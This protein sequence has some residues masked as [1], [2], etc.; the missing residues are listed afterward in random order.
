MNCTFQIT[1]TTFKHRVGAPI[2]QSA[3]IDRFSVL[4]NEEFGVQLIIRAEDVFLAVQ[5]QRKDISWQG[6]S[7]Q[8]R[9]CI[10]AVLPNGD[11]TAETPGREIFFI[12]LMDFVRDDNGDWISDILT[13][14]RS[15]H[16]IHKEQGIFVGGKI[17]PNFPHD[18]V[19]LHIQIFYTKSYES[20]SL[21][22]EIFLP[23]EISKYTL[24]NIETTDF[25]T[26]LW[27]HPC[28]WARAYDVAYYEEEHFQIIDHYLA[29]L[30]ALGQKVCDLIISDFPWA[31]QRCYKVF[32]NHNNLFEINIIKIFKEIDGR[33]TCDFSAMDRYISLCSKHGIN[34]EINLFGILG[35]WD[36][37]DFGN[38]LHDFKDPIRLSYLDRATQTYRYMTSEA[39]IE[40]YLTLVFDHLDEKGLWDKTLILSD[41]PSNVDL[42]ERSVR[43]FKRAAKGK[44]IHL[45][46]AIHDWQFFENY[47]KHIKSLSLNTCELVHNAKSIHTLKQTIEDKGGTLTWYSC[48]FPTPMNIFLKSPLI[49]SR[50]IGWFT[51]Y[52][53]LDGFLRWAYG[54][55]P[56]DV[57]QNASYKKEKW[58]AGDMFLVYPGKQGKPLC[59]LRLKNILHGIQDYMFLKAVQDKIGRDALLQK[60]A[61]LLGSKDRMQFIPEREVFLEHDL[62]IFSYQKLKKELLQ[63]LSSKQEYLKKISDSVVEMDEDSILIAIDHALANNVSSDEI[64]EQGLSDG[65]LRVTKLFE[66]REYFVSEVIVCADTL[67]KGI[68]YLKS[69]FPLSSKDGPKVVMG[70]VEGDLHEIGK[71]IVKILFEAAGFDVIDMGLNVKAQDIVHKA[72]EERADIIG[73]S[74]MMT[75]TMVKMKEVIDLLSDIQAPNRP[76][77]IIGG[78]CI[79]EKY[80][81]EIGAD[82][83]SANAVEAVKLVQRLTGGNDDEL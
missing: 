24:A 76:K 11:Q 65:M 57:Y 15:I 66:D 6:L 70:V 4:K 61:L 23:I 33:F 7:H 51:Y 59:S 77:V 52:M 31:G 10:R 67:N 82:G 55:W 34:Q 74:T 53:G 60:L 81:R 29:G 1:D 8:F 56:G 2:D 46:C 19:T 22:H 5:G 72:I 35:N 3:S 78:G 71:N 83:Y 75:T 73:L 32:E 30:S 28:N 54:V 68:N 48:C 44:S 64:Y 13:D 17:P 40:T 14:K 38:P 20:E 62:S 47:G 58:A 39:E 21:I 25:Y 42:F 45:K 37:L 16:A 43:L 63:T 41:E 9:I 80:S 79:S 18:R 69:K 36:A 27:Q 49:E 26:D 12:H 50:L